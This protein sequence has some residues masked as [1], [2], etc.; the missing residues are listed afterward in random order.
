MTI[1]DH[2]LLKSNAEALRAAQLRRIFRA[3]AIEWSTFLH[4]FAPATPPGARPHAPHPCQSP[5]APHP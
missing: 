4:R 5:A 2:N 1:P 3:L